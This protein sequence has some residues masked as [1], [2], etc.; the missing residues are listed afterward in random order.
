MTSDHDGLLSRRRYH[1]QMIV[2]E[3]GC[4]GQARLARSAV[5]IVGMGGLGSPAALYVAAAGV[6]RLGLIDADVVDLSNLHRQILHTTP[7]VGLPKVESARQALQALNPHCRIEAEHMRFTAENAQ[8]LVDA[9]DCVIDGTDNFASRYLISDACTA[10]GKPH[11][12]GSVQ[13]TFGQVTVFSADRGPCYRCLYP[14]APPPDVAPACAEAGVLG[15]VPGVIGLLQATEVM[16]LVLGEGEPLIGRLLRY[17]A[18]TTR[19]TELQ[20]IRDAACRC[21]ARR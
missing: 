19:W 15:V 1:R 13:R 9:Y 5:L 4:E 7:R 21:A 11:I 18:L 10:A 16:K 20:I 2:P 12:Y 17:D 8:R 6:G 3:V 14:E